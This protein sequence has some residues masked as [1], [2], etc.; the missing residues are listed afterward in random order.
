MRVASRPTDHKTNAIGFTDNSDDDKVD[1]TSLANFF[2]IE[3]L[4]RFTTLLQFNELSP[5]DYRAIVKEQYE[6]EAARINA[7]HFGVKLPDTIPDDDLNAIVNDTYERQFGAR[8][9]HR[10]VRQYIEEIA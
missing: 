3:L 5:E 8:P 4:N 6:E 9:A 7:E 1:I 10:A 2:D